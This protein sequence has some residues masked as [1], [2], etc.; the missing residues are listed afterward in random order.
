MLS[1]TEP[2]VIQSII[3]IISSIY[4]SSWSLID[5]A[6]SQSVSRSAFSITCY[7]VQTTAASAID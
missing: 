3:I 7:T 1:M 2:K 4:M 5:P 6:V